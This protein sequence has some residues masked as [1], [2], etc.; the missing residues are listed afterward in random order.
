MNPNEPATP[1]ASPT[2]TSTFVPAAPPPQ[3]P[4]AVRP[5]TVVTP[6]LAKMQAEGLTQNW[7]L[8]DE[9]WSALER[10]CDRFSKSSMVPNDYSGKP[11]NVFVALV[12]GLPL[13]LSP[14]ACLQSVA[15]IN[16]RPSLFGD[17]PIAQV[18]AHPSL[19]DIKEEPSGTLKGGD[20]EWS[21]TVKRRL[22]N[23]V[24][25]VV[26]R[27]YSIADAR[28]AGLWGKQGPWTTAP[29]RMIFNRARAFAL[30]DAFAD[31]LKGVTLAADRYEEEVKD[32]DVRVVDVPTPAAPTT[33][34]V[35]ETAG[36]A[37]AKPQEPPAD[38][39]KRQRK[40]S[41]A[42]AAASAALNQAMAEA[43]ATPATAA[44]PPS[45]STKGPKLA[46]PPAAAAELQ[47]GD[48]EDYADDAPMSSEVEPKE[49]PPITP[50]TAVLMP[51]ADVTPGELGT[52][53]LYD[54]GSVRRWDGDDFVE[55]ADA[56]TAKACADQARLA[57]RHRIVAHCKKANFD[58]AKS[59]AWL[60]EVLNLP[61]VPASSDALS[62]DQLLAV[63]RSLDG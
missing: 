34:T 58:R 48:V 31:V 4:S 22:P 9:A 60:A 54:N 27:T 8:H 24:P 6:A 36:L 17:A 51:W 11:G 49:L 25:L 35:V 40:S 10:L 63:V 53:M 47:A 44:T 46:P 45:A 43:A 21:I 38:Q 32:V 55:P 15:V 59:M 42:A 19:Q 2:N 56:A 41:A 7:W 28:T 57:M 37:P 29:D 16:G 50:Q 14:L 62:L 26:T 33:S 52:L 61:G 3:L 30:R 39:P 20:R 5:P 18:L 1:V 13:G 23:G 12:A